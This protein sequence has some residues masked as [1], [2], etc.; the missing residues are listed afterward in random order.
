MRTAPTAARVL[1]YVRASLARPSGRS[2][3]RS[4]QR[5]AASESCQELSQTGSRAAG[6]RLHAAAMPGMCEAECTSRGQISQQRAVVHTSTPTRG[7]VG[8]LSKPAGQYHSHDFDWQELR[9]DPGVPL[10]KAAL[11][12]IAVLAP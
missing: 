11:Q 5:I 2:Q 8:G 9:D 10:S 12:A 1:L 4:D 6:G 7:W 3:S